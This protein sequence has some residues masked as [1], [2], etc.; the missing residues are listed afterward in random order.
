MVAPSQ[1][2]MTAKDLKFIRRPMLGI[3]G[4]EPLDPAEADRLGVPLQEGLRL[5][6]VIAGLG[7]AA[8][9]LQA[10][11]VIVA[12][13]GRSIASPADLVKVMETH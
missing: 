5:H 13:D 7:A 10:E 3:D 2:Q 9:G 8:A 1:L 4:F 12:I 11:D 6:G